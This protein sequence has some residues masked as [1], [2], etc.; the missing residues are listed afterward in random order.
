MLYVIKCLASC[1]SAD[2]ERSHRCCHLSNKVENTDHTS[3]VLYTLQSVE[4]CPQNSTFPWLNA[5]PTQAQYVVPCVHPTPKRQIDWLIR[6]VGLT[7][8]TNRHTQRPRY[9]CGNRPRVS[10]MRCGLKIE[11]SAFS[12]ILTQ[13]RGFELGAEIEFLTHSI[14]DG[15]YDKAQCVA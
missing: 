6:F 2:S 5:G 15:Q 8:V 4:R 3:S 14:Y 1:C 13:F 12:E 9:I 11:P 7:I 10:R